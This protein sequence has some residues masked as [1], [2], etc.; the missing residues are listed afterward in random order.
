M[1]KTTEKNEITLKFPFALANGTTLYKITLRRPK[2][3]D[4]KNADK[5]GGTAAERE[6]VLFSML[7][8]PALV[9]EDMEEM[10]L[11][12][13]GQVQRRFQAMVA[14]PGVSV[15]GLGAAGPVVSVPAV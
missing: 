2:V 1:D 11:A 3:R 9:P 14:D 6:L 4:L 5:R 8:T 10:D 7:C 13:Y 12:D 15:G